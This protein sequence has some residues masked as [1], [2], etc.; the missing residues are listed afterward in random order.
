MNV[1][2][3]RLRFSHALLTN[4]GKVRQRNEDMAD[5]DAKRGVYVLAD[6][7]GGHP[8]GNVASKTAVVALI[9]HIIGKG[10]RDRPAKLRESVLVAN[11]AVL[12]LAETDPSMHGMGTTLCVVWLSQAR[13]YI[14]HIGDSRI[15]VIRG[16][17][18]HQVTRDHTVV[19]EL[20]ER[21][22]LTEDSIEAQRMGHILTQAVGLDPN[23]EPDLGMIPPQPGDV[24]LMCSD[25]LSDIVDDSAMADI[26]KSSE[27]LDEAAQRLV[28]AGL[29]AGGHDN[30]TVLL[31]R[32][33]EAFGRKNKA[34]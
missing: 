30:I 26:V 2:R 34:K 17:E 6:G 1:A 8:A 29:D 23:V 32:V 20:I 3:P 21:G 7:M 11:R 31:V 4:V 15:Y 33:D 25:G 12:S 16:D 5:V 27:N 14:A 13:A 28:Q 10:T 22:E 18:I 9:K 19:R 24:F